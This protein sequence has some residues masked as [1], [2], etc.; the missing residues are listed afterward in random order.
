MAMNRTLEDF[1]FHT[2]YRA[3]FKK[4]F[5]DFRLDDQKKYRR[6]AFC[7]LS[8]KSWAFISAENP[9]SIKLSE[10]E[11]YFRSGQLSR[12]LS[13][14]KRN[15]VP[16][17]GIPD[18]IDWPVELGFFILN[19][20]MSDAKYIGNKFQQ[21]AILWFRPMSLITLVWLVESNLSCENF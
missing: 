1:Y 7:H 16:G 17:L 9:Y 5:I 2:T 8:I 14:K 21:N 13:V 19:I 4:K 12:Y 6:L 10:R 11:N 3:L 15:Y 18:C 20:S